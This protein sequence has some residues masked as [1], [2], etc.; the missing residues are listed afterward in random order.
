MSNE[1]IYQLDDLVREF[2]QEYEAFI[3]KGNGAAGTRARKKLSEMAQFSKDTRAHIQ[4][5]KNNPNP[6]V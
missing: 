5:I 6:T 1:V 2:K 4:E 3:E